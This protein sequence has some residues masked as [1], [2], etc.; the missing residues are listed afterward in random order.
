MHRSRWPWCLSR[1]PE[2]WPAI[3]VEQE[4][5]CGPTMASGLTGESSGKKWLLCDLGNCLSLSPH[6]PCSRVWGVR[7][8]KQNGPPTSLQTPSHCFCGLCP[9]DCTF[10]SI[11]G[12]TFL[13]GEA[14]SGR[15]SPVARLPGGHRHFGDRAE[16]EQG[17]EGGPHQGQG[18]TAPAGRVRTTLR[19]ARSPEHPADE[20]GGHD[21][22]CA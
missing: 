13:P 15:W 12:C 19:T 2:S 20:A 4:N 11:V 9:S 17:T 22:D 6:T 10:A 7:S 14:S 5:C 1:S 18:S 16:R 3:Q 8:R 21:G